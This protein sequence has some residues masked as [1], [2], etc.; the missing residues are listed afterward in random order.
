MAHWHFHLPLIIASVA[1]QT[2]MGHLTESPVNHSVTAYNTR[3]NRMESEKEGPLIQ[4]TNVVFR[5]HEQILRQIHPSMG[6][7]SQ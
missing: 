4:T 2:M 1:L 7:C 6:L 3:T 5:I